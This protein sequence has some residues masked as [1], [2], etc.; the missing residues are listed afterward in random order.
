MFLAHGTCRKPYKSLVLSVSE[1]LKHKKTARARP[2]IAF[3][4]ATVCLVKSLS[5]SILLQL[6][7]LLIVSLENR[8]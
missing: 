5:V 1:N 6:V 4:I 8:I 7:L 3:F 2:A